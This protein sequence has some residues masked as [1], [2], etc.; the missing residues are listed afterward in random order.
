MAD[1]S[2]EAASAQSEW[3]GQKTR[4]MRVRLKGLVADPS[5]EAASAKSE[6]LVQVRRRMNLE[7]KGLVADLSRRSREWLG[8]KTRRM[9]VK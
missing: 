2:D 4:R 3:L 5:D 8:Q 6:W 7:L 9:K 1:P